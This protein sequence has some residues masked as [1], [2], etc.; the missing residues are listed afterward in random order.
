MHMKKFNLL[1]AVL[2]SFTAVQIATADIITLTDGSIIH[3]TVIQR[4]GQDILIL[5]DYGT[6][7]LSASVVQT[8]KTEADK[9]PV[10]LSVNTVSKD[11]RIPDWRTTIAKLASEGWATQLRQIPATV[12]TNGDMRNVPYIS[13]RCGTDFEVNVYGDLDNPAGVEIGFYRSLLVGDKREYATGAALEFMNSLLQRENDRATLAK[14]DHT[15]DL[16]TVDGFTLE[17]TPETADDAY[18]GWWVSAYSNKAL[19]QARVSDQELANISVL[20]SAIIKSN[21]PV[22]A[23]SWTKDDLRYARP[24]SPVAPYNPSATTVYQAA[25]SSYGY[26]DVAPEHDHGSVYVHGYYR[27]NGTYVSSYTRR[28]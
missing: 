2:C 19:D 22:V 11:A 9:Q 25:D 16:Q 7:S 3:G 12:I 21:E 8:V 24:S 6:T 27:S 14:L 28:R 15:K 5:A 20:N 4:D 13:F 26:S 17:I 23:G 1:L 10:T 18:G